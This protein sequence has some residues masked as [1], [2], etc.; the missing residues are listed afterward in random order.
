MVGANDSLFI[1]E[2]HSWRLDVAGV[3]GKSAEF[4]F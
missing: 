4:I 3:N 1:F 2:I